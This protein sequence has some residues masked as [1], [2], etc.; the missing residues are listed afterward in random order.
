MGYFEGKKILIYGTGIKSKRFIECMGEKAT[1]IGVLDRSKVA[2][3]FCSFPIIDWESSVVDDAEILVI[4]S[5]WA[6]YREIYRRELFQCRRHHLKVY[7]DTE[8]NLDELFATTGVDADAVRYFRWSKERLIEEMSKYDSI[9][10]DIFDTLLTRK[11]LEPID[12]FYLLEKRLK[13]S[14]SDLNDFAR[15]RRMADVKS[16]GG[17]IYKIYKIIQDEYGLSNSDVEHLIREEIKI[18]KEMLT[19]RTEMREVFEAA[20]SSGKTVTLI[21]DMYFTTDIIRSFLDELNIRGYKKIMISCEAGVGKSNGLFRIY[22]D[23]MPAWN[24]CLH[25]GDDYGADVMSPRREGISAVRIYSPFELL[26]ISS[27]SGCLNN[28]R[29]FSDK[30]WLGKMCAELFNDPFC[31]SKTSGIVSLKTVELLGRYFVAPIVLAFVNTVEKCR[32]DNDNRI[33]LWGARD[34]WLFYNVYN[35]VYGNEKSIYFYCSRKQCFRATLCAETWNEYKAVFSKYKYVNKLVGNMFEL[36][37]IR[38]EEDAQLVLN[39]ME[40][41]KKDILNTANNERMNE[42]SYLNKSNIDI[43]GE[44][45]FT[46]LVSTGTVHSC[47]NKLFNKPIKGVYFKYNRGYVERDLHVEPM[48]TDSEWRLSVD[49]MNFLEFVFSS[50]EPSLDRFTND[51]KTV[52]ERETRSEI[53]ISTMVRMQESIVGEIESFTKKYG[54]IFKYISRE[55]ARDFLAEM[56]NIELEGNVK[57]IFSNLKLEDNINNTDFLKIHLFED[58]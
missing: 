3:T 4:A 8:Y 9:S 13:A 48:Y 23:G 29:T 37:T 33:I 17:S 42:L 22:K 44:Y 53:E 26:R 27:I 45:I 16:Q 19:V 5:S 15:V 52:F 2:G 28:I 24:K 12:V 30:I 32:E 47:L 20:V 31:L 34:G 49:V 46:D 18:E 35:T 14:Y 7:S 11:V 58:G 39:R 50:P 43:D 51:G 38:K 41:N 10:F 40:D 6:N 56:A 57:S 25:I 21:S 55:F 54:D 1:I 36:E